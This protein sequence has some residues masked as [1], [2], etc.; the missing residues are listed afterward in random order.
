MRHVF[1]VLLAL[2][3]CM[4]SSD[5]DEV[6]V[7]DCPTAEEREGRCADETMGGD[8]CS[9]TGEEDCAAGVLPTYPGSD[10]CALDYCAAYCAAG[11]DWRY[12]GF[13]LE[14]FCYCE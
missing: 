4:D 11:C 9:A 2:V 12:F 7:A 14:F 8:C 6:S 5:D 1:L 10:D 13:D 3:G